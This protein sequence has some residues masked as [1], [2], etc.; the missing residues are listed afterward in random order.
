[1]QQ[2]HPITREIGMREAFLVEITALAPRAR[3]VLTLT[4]TQVLDS[5]VK[6]LE[7]VISF[8][9]LGCPAAFSICFKERGRPDVETSKMR[10]D[11]AMTR[12]PGMEGQ[13][14]ALIHEVVKIYREVYYTLRRSQ[15]DQAAAERARE[16]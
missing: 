16:E 14:E 15:V 8:M 7:R 9:R 2:E 4:K 11:W 13:G 10:Q 12:D 1:M 5:V 3:Q 6:E